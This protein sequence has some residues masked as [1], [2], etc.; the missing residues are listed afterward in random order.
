MLWWDFLEVQ[1]APV[2]HAPVSKPSALNKPTGTA[3]QTWIEWMLWYVI[4]L[5]LGVTELDSLGILVRALPL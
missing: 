4:V 3:R 2:T 1:L 5:C